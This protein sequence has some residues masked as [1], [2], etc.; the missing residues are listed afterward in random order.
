MND[1]VKA[2]TLLVP[3]AALVAGM[4][5]ATLWQGWA[6]VI[7][8]FAGILPQWLADSNPGVAPPDG[9]DARAC[10]DQHGM[11]KLGDVLAARLQETREGL[12]SVE[13]I[14]SD[15]STTLQDS[16]TDIQRLIHEQIEQ[17]NKLMYPDTNNDSEA[18]MNTR[19]E[20]FV[21]EASQTLNR[22]VEITVQMSSDAMGLVERVNSVSQSMPAVMKAMQDI[23]EIADQTNLLALNAAIEAARAGESGRGFAVV[24]DEVRNLSKRSAEFSKDIQDR[25]KGIST[26]FEQLK[27][28]VGD[29]ASQDMSFVMDAKK[30]VQSTVETLF[31]KSEQDREIAGV[32]EKH[33]QQL[34]SDINH[35][36]RA[37]QFED[38]ARQ[39]IHFTR[40]GVEALK[41]LAQA[42]D[43]TAHQDSAQALSEALAT[44]QAAMT[45]RDESPVSARSMESGDV[46]LF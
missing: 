23:D 8:T 39:T 10:E 41:P 9:E 13:Q 44:Y 3:L 6:G 4:A 28:E 11:D 16:F 18:N 27:E 42:L 1:N 20:Q 40:E 31:S 26:S 46:D 12:D 24:A 5:I 36:I 37:L 33:A 29:V 34:D 45:A 19:M 38:M 30:N 2:V 22:F 35:A 7:V 14:Q 17:L 32:V 15:A 21:Q 43:T 25:L